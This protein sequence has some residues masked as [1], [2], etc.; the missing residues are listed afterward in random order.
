M[1]TYGFLL[2]FHSN[3]GPIFYRFQDIAKYRTKIANFPIHPYLTPPERGS[4]WK[5]VTPL[6]GAKKLE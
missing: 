5:C 1:G 6:L 3:H 2:I 4:S